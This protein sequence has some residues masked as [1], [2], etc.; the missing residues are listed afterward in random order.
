VVPALEHALAAAE[1]ERV[2]VVPAPE[3]G[4]VAVLLRTKSVIAVH[5][6]GQVHLAVEDLAVAAETMREPAAAEAATA[7]AAAE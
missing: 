4:P 3:R 6:R 5:R 2:P 1:L 7:W